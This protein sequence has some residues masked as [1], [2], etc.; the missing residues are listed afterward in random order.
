MPDGQRLVEFND[1]VREP[2][3]AKPS[4]KRE[5]EE[6]IVARRDPTKDH[7]PGNGRAGKVKGP[8]SRMAVLAQVVGPE[9]LECPESPHSMIS[10]MVLMES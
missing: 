8:R 1:K 6:R 4:E 2:G 10:K 7:E 9:L 3:E 5:K